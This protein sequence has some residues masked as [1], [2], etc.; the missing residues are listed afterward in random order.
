MTNDFTSHEIRTQADGWMGA[1]KAL[2]DKHDKIITLWETGGY[3]SIFFT[4]CGSTHYLA[5]TAANLAQ[6]AVGLAC[7]GLP[8]SELVF[9]PDHIYP[10]HGKPL[11][12]TLS[13]SAE[14]SETIKAAQ[15]FR[16][17]FGDHVVTI[18]CYGERALNKEATLTMAIHEGQEKSIAQT[19][20]FASMLVA[21]EGFAQIISGRNLSLNID[22]ADMILRAEEQSKQYID[23]ERFDRFFYLGAGP[24]YGVACE[25]MLKM[26][27]MSQTYAEAYHPLEFRHGPKA[28][29]NERTVVIGLLDGPNYESELAVLNDM[30]ALGATILNISPH[31]DADFRLLPSPAQVMYLPFTQWMAY[32]RAIAKSLNPDEPNNLDMVVYI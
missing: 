28:M 32:H 1:V 25:A 13:R 20:S 24:R 23:V 8:A 27:E 6:S 12:V 26:K 31:A 10:T 15:A 21:S 3:D 30:E 4:G 18:T 17:R 19:R 5:L 14:T 2:K 29:V 16:Q 22:S 11:L 7:R 9:Y